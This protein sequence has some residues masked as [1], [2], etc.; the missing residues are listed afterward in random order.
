MRT[1][2]GRLTYLISHRPFRTLCSSF[3]V[4]PVIFRALAEQIASQ[5]NQN[6]L[7]PDPSASSP[8][9][10]LN[11][12]ASYIRSNLSDF[13]RQWLATQGEAL[14]ISSEQIMSDVLAEWLTRHRHATRNGNFI[15]DFLQQALED[16][17]LRHHEEFLPV[18]AIE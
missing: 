8:E 1:D 6:M 14:N 4:L 15:G 5:L 12:I 2:N 11:Q 17:I 7:D 18:V 10:Q 9:D 13:Q 3:F 16:F